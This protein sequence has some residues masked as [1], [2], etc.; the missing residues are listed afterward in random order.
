MKNLVDFINEASTPSFGKGEAL[1]GFKWKK[2]TNYKI[3]YN[4]YEKRYEIFSDETQYGPGRVPMYI[5]KTTDETIGVE[6]VH[7]VQDKFGKGSGS[8]SYGETTYG[9]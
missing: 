8:I 6:I 2:N 5:F 4:K 3:R 7:Y 1:N 9:F